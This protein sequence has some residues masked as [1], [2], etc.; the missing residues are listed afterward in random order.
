M[1]RYLAAT[2]VLG[3]LLLAVGVAMAATTL[4]QGGGPLATGVVIGG[5]FALAGAGRLWLAWSRPE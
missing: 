5:A 4:A 3:M 2:R 1:T